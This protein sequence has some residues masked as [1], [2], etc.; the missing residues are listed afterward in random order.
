MAQFELAAA[1]VLVDEGAYEPPTEADPGG[2]TKFGISKRAYPEED[3]RNLTAARARQIY[4]RDFWRFEEV[5]DQDVANLLLDV[6]VQL[7][8]AGGTRLLQQALVIFYP[9]KGI[10][11]DGVFGPVTLAMVNGCKAAAL[12]NELRARRAQRICEDLRKNPAEAPL[13]LG[14]FRRACK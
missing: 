9:G 4:E 13:S 5:N 14:L 6:C 1:F 12:L 3:I 8:R 10:A 2:E 7:G 11:L